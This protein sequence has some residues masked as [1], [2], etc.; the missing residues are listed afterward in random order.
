MENVKSNIVQE[1]E[2]FLSAMGFSKEQRAL[3]H[4]GRALHTM[5]R[6]QTEKGHKKNALDK[7]NYNGMDKQAISRF[8]IELFE[9]SRHYDISNKIEWPWGAFSRN[10]DLQKWDMDPH[11]ALFYI[12]SGYTYLIKTKPQDEINESDNQN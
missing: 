6:K 3:F 2:A 9:A 10:F 11:E 1:E 7:L 8:S 5:V 4:L 12:L